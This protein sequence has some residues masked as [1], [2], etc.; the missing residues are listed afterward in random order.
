[1]QKSAARLNNWYNATD[2]LGVADIFTDD[3]AI[4]RHV[5]D[6]TTGARTTACM[7][8]A[9]LKRQRPNTFGSRK[10]YE[11]SEVHD[12]LHCISYV[13]SYEISID[14]QR[15][16]WRQSSMRIRMYDPT[17]GY[18]LALGVIFFSERDLMQNRVLHG[19]T[20]TNGA[21]AAAAERR[22]SGIS[23]SGDPGNVAT[24]ALAD[25]PRAGPRSPDRGGAA[26]AAVA[27]ATGARSRTSQ[28]RAAPPPAQASPSKKPCEQAVR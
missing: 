20:A 22:N 4:I 1:M 6:S 9:D 15:R 27:A 28:K 16:T 11:L 8:A 26:P 18:K 12:P 13:Q 10:K 3:V 14:E 2:E 17:R 23:A 25:V 24:A 21:H 7:G 19:C 5:T